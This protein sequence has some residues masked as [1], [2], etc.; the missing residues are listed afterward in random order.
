M[1]AVLFLSNDVP[2]LP[3]FWLDLH[4]GDS[5]CRWVMSPVAQVVC[6]QERLEGN[7]RFCHMRV[8]QHAEQVSFA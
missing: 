6:Q 8:R 7:L 4:G 5:S 3:Y 2:E 1:Q